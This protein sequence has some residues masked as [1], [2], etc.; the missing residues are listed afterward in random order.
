M[1]ESFKNLSKSFVSKG[2]VGKGMDQ[3]F[4]I[5]LYGMDTLAVQISRKNKID[6]A[7]C[8]VKI[9]PKRNLVHPLKAERSLLFAGSVDPGTAQTLST[10]GLA[11]SLMPWSRP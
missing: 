7:V 9:A 10:T 3:I 6:P 2:I 8:L 11:S 4:S 1:N 5:N